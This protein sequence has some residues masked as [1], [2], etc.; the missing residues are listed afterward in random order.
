MEEPDWKIERYCKTLNFYFHSEF[1][2]IYLC[3]FPT[4]SYSFL[5]VKCKFDVRNVQNFFLFL[6]YKDPFPFHPS[7]PSRVWSVGARCPWFAVLQRGWDLP[8]WGVWCCPGEQPNRALPHLGVTLRAFQTKACAWEPMT[9]NN[10]LNF[11]LY[12][13][14]YHNLGFVCPFASLFLYMIDY[15]FFSQI[16]GECYVALRE[17]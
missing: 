2:Q 5:N 6:K 16:L 7:L 17:L 14:W 4:I 9:I 11:S 3:V 10:H 8:A 1:L 13:K 12:I 15:N